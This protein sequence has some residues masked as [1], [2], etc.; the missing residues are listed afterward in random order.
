MVSPTVVTDS[1]RPGWTGM[2]ELYPKCT[3][4]S[5][6][7]LQCP[8]ACCLPGF[9]GYW[10]SLLLWEAMK[11]GYHLKF[12]PSLGVL[13]ILVVVMEVLIVVAM[14]ERVVLLMRGKVGEEREK[15]T[16]PECDVSRGT[17]L[18]GC[19]SEAVDAHVL[20]IQRPRELACWGLLWLPVEES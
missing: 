12:A 9:L 17:P 16:V 20:S 10:V 2:V 7:L 5:A 14:K 6:F 13:G 8:L 3:N 11:Q 4:T 18:L 15:G 19:T 1:G